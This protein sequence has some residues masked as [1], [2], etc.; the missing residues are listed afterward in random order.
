MGDG[1]RPYGNQHQFNNDEE[2]DDYGRVQR[3]AILLKNGATYTG[4]WL[5]EVREGF[6]FQVWPDGSKYEGFWRNDKANG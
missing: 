5:G 1:N 6:G 3:G 4:Q 2:C